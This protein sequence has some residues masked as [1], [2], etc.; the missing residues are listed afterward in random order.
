[1]NKKTFAKSVAT[2]IVGLG[3][4]TSCNAIKEK[5]GHDKCAGANSCKGKKTESHGCK[6]K[7]ESHGCGS[8]GCEA[9]GNGCKGKK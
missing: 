3:L 9:D 8:N 5:M 1:M 6:G 2:A 7:K 4:L